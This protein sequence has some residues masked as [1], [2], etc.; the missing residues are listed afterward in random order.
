[1]WRAKNYITGTMQVEIN[2]LIKS[3]I[4]VQLRNELHGAVTCRLLNDQGQVLS[5]ISACKSTPVWTARFS[6]A[7]LKKG[8]YR[9]IVRQDQYMAVQDLMVP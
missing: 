1:M 2:P 9:V 4:S 3:R 8:P 5:I 6:A 7:D